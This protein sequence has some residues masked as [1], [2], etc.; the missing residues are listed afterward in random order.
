MPDKRVTV[1]VQRFADRKYL[2]LQWIDPDTG[3]RRSRSA[4]TD[5]EAEAEKAR[6]DLEYELNHGLHAEPSKMTWARFRE[7]VEK[8]YRPNLKPKTLPV[9]DTVLDQFE[10]FCNPARLSAI[11]ERMLS[12][13]VAA[14]RESPGRRGGKM[15]PSTIQTKLNFLQAILSWAASQKYLIAVPKFPEVSV[16]KKKPQPVPAEVFERLLEKAPDDQMRAFLLCGWLAGLRLAEADSLEWEQNDKAP[17]LDFPRD[18]IWLP[19][20]FVKAK[21]DQWVPI[22]PALRL[23]LEGLPRQGVKV[24]RFVTKGG[25]PIAEGG[26]SYRIVALARKVGIKMSMRTLR[27]GFGCRYAGKVPAQVLQKLMRHSKI[28]ITMQYYANV[29]DAV[30][31]AILGPKR[32]TQC[33]SR[34]RTAP[35]ESCHE[36]HK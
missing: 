26:I 1:W 35:E 23:A 11:N 18:R 31:E 25:R 36:T 10:N 6:A 5:D 8:E 19:A 2:M 32:N 30:E 14:L 17:W 15:M 9:V 21:E 29:D 12:R 27:R 34:P 24:F 20:E 28:D 7:I 33:N 16:P 4:K 13:F 3:K 22:D